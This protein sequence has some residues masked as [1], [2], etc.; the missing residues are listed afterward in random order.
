MG[1]ITLKEKTNFLKM[2]A[3]PTRLMILEELVKGVK[4][5]ND[6]EEL[7]EVR[8]PN[9]SQ[10]LAMLRHSGL[11]DFYQKGKKRCYFLTRKKT[12]RTIV[13]GLKKIRR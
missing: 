3:H 11:V 8:Q 9:I 7:L 1:K 6:I 10:H 13:K 5:V 2:L 4:C 12:I